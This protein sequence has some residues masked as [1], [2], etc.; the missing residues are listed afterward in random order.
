MRN[1]FIVEIGEEIF[2]LFIKYDV[3]INRIFNE[4]KVLWNIIYDKCSIVYRIIIYVY[5]IVI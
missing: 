5:G 3:I 1:K 2:K 4:I